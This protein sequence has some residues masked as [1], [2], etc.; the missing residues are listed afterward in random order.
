MQLVS[1]LVVITGLAIASIPPKADI[2]L[3]PQAVEAGAVRFTNNTAGT[4][5]VTANGGDLFTD[6]AAGETT[7]WAEV[8]DS[9][10]T[11]VMKSATAPGDSAWATQRIAEGGRYSLIGGTGA[12]GKPTL[13]I[14]AGEAKPTDTEG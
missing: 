4:A 9:M 8:S 3:P 11:F 14:E 7:R 6:V 1:T 12:D 5:S 2:T 13:K 10:V